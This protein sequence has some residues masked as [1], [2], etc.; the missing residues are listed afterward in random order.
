MTA[1]VAAAIAGADA[2]AVVL[3]TFSHAPVAREMARAGWPHDRP[4][5]L[6]P[7]HTGGA[8]EFAHAFAGVNPAVPPIVEFSTLTYVARKY[9]DDQVTVT[10]RAR[11]VRAAALPGAEPALELAATL[12]P[13]A[14]PVANVLVADLANAN[15]IL[16]PPGA[17]LASA[18]VEA[19]AGDFTFYVDAMTP[20]VARVMRQLDD[21]RRAVAAAFGFALPNLIEEM[22][23]IGTVEASVRD[24]DDFVAAIAGGEANKRIK[25]PGSLQHRYYRE[26]FGH[27]LLPFLELARIAEVEV[28]V[29]A[30][31]FALAGALC[32]VDFRQG[33]RTAQAMGI[34][35]MSKP[36][37][38]GRVTGR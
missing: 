22:K 15:L 5:V 24:T 10:G 35:G 32:G 20:G 34:A 1:D 33:G 18:W 28:P 14:T 23:L 7:G 21:E 31:L 26:D 16:H 6:N 13:G 36:Q 4:V 2:A 11:Q 8:L 37:L 38:L 9:R 19:R 30:A 29:A 25:G 17:I 3:P 12:F 27:G